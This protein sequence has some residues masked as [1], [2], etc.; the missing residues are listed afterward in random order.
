LTAA[1]LATVLTAS[2]LGSLHCAG[3]CGGFVA[4][5]AGSADGKSRIAAHFAY[6]F[7]RLLTYATFGAVAGLLGAALDLAGELAGLQR[8]AALVAGSLMVAWGLAA[9][10]SALGWRVP[11]LRLPAGLAGLARRAH[12]SAAAR[13]P[14]L[15]ALLVGLLTTILPCGW[16]HAFTISAAGTAS[17]LAGVAIMTAFWLGTLPVLSAVGASVQ[18]LSAPL[19][20]QVPVVSALLILTIGLLALADRVP[21]PNG[22][23]NA[24]ACCHA[25]G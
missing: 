20:R 21:M 16:L 2:L 9:L 13:P 1:V 7:G 25:D 12:A 10:G 18:A 14:V 8:V 24:A 5:W 4:F 6:S 17:P 3:M 19:R 11:G 15:R 23:P 22:E